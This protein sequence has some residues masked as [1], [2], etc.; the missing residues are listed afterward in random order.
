MILIWTIVCRCFKFKS[1]IQNQIEQHQVLCWAFFSPDRWCPAGLNPSWQWTIYE[2]STSIIHVQFTSINIHH[3][4]FIHLFTS[5]IIHQISSMYMYLLYLHI[6]YHPI[7]SIIIHSFRYHPFTS[8][9]GPQ[10]VFC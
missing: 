1:C 4:P 7:T 2:E 3:N 6:Y 9:R 8:G 10:M 5:I